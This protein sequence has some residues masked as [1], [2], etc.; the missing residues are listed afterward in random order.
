MIYAIANWKCNPVSAKE[1]KKISVGILKAA[2]AARGVETII[3]PPFCYLGEVLAVVKKI[4][5]LGAQDCYWEEKGAFTGEQSAWQLK[6][7]GCLYVIIG[8]SERRKYFGETSEQ[9]NKKVKAALAAGLTPILCVGETRE[10][11]IGGKISDVIEA[12]IKQGLAGIE[13]ADLKRLLM[14]YEPVWAIGTGEACSIDEAKY[15]R[16]MIYNQVG[17]GVAI[18][19]GGS[20]NA[21]NALSYIKDGG[22]TGLLVGG[23]SLKPAEFSQLLANVSEKPKKKK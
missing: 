21:D 23:V 17:E 3:C 18:L 22:F 13:P 11:R 4:V 6:D 7:V 8:H 20:A 12:Q 16:Q 15:V 5:K 10:D 9:T 19:Y 1:A 2:K 14:A